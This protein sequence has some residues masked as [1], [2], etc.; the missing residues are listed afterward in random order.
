MVCSRVSGKFFTD[1]LGSSLLLW[2]SFSFI[3]DLAQQ[4]CYPEIGRHSRHVTLR[5]LFL[6]KKG[7]ATTFPL[8]AFTS[9]G[10]LK[11]SPVNSQNLV[12]RVYFLVLSFHSKVFPVLFSLLY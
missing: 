7:A 5:E 6:R 9:K 8:A 11:T 12:I 4:K 2:G 10:I 3:T 1:S